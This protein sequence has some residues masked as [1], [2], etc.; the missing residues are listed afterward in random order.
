MFVKIV[1]NLLK[2]NKKKN[3]KLRSTRFLARQL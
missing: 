3:G 2:L 1:N